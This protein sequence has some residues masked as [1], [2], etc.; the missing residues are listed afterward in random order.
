M[1]KALSEEKCGRPKLPSF[2]RQGG[3]GSSREDGVGR[4]YQ[5]AKA[6]FRTTADTCAMFKAAFQWSAQALDLFSD[7][8]QMEQCMDDEH[9]YKSKGHTLLRSKVWGRN[10]QRAA[11]YCSADTESIAYQCSTSAV[12]SARVRLE[13]LLSINRHTKEKKGCHKELFPELPSMLLLRGG[14]RQV[15]RRKK[16]SERY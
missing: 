16:M 6:K 4:H 1:G 8:R 12:R 9:A 14:L 11:V 15:R 13:V 2:C 7:A 3:D 5:E 10:A